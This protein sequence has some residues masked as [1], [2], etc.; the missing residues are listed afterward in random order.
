MVT[1]CESSLKNIYQVTK[2]KIK[3]N[4]GTFLLL[5]KVDVIQERKEF[6]K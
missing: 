2:Y 4:P 6:E 1:F 5:Q 3:D